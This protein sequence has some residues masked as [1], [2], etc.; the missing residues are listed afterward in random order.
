MW[1]AVIIATIKEIQCLFIKTFLNKCFLSEYIL[2]CNAKQNYQHPLLQSS[3]S[4]YSTY[5]YHIC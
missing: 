1:T 3:V 5:H 2:K 4:H